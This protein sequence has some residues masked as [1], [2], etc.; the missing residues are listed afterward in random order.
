[1]AGNVQA[2]LLLHAMSPG[3]VLADQAG[4]VRLPRAATVPAMARDLDAASAL[5]VDDPLAFPFESLRRVD[6]DLPMVVRL[7]SG[8]DPTAVEAVLGE[9]L[10]DHLTPFDLLVGPPGPTAR[11]LARRRLPSSAYAGATDG[12]LEALVARASRGLNRVTAA[13]R[14]GPAN[15]TLLNVTLP[16][17]PEVEADRRLRYLKRRLRAELA[18]LS[19]SLVDLAGEQP[20]TRGMH[21][22]IA[23]R[24]PGAFASALPASVES[25][26]GIRL[27]P[28]ADD[29]ADLPSGHGDLVEL[30]A[31]GRVPLP[32]AS[33][34]AVVL[35]GEVLHAPRHAVSRLVAELERLVRP[36]G[37][38]V[39]LVDVVADTLAER[40]RRSSPMST[41][42]LLD[43]AGEASGRRFALEDVRA[44]RR[45]GE[46]HHRAGVFVLRSLRTTQEAAAW[47]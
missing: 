6:R 3:G 11:V 38:L 37:W 30:P 28:G 16:A 23:A 45:P 26:S 12:D 4:L 7:P 47:T 17:V 35:A 22:A 18:A 44:L 27:V 46:P 10:L 20:S 42:E 2:P 41:L 19:R 39:A 29:G 24:R 36:G 34:D 32:A 31:S 8:L 33:F 25:W 13:W 14:P 5:L 40:D 15:P 43:L 9:V 21:V 1:M